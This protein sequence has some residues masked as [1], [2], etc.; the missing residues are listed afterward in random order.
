M[1]LGGMEGMIY[2]D[3]LRSEYAVV[4]SLISLSSVA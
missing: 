3:D 1:I 2:M 4:S